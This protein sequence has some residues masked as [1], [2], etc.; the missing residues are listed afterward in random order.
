MLFGHFLPVIRR[1]TAHTGEQLR[2]LIPLLSKRCKQRIRRLASFLCLLGSVKEL[3]DPLKV[4][5]VFGDLLFDQVRGAHNSF[6][7][8]D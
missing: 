3:V 5:F 6:T 4:L 8:S 2:Q 1:L 7:R